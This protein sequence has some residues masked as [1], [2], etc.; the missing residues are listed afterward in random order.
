MSNQVSE[1][2]APTGVGADPAYAVGFLLRQAHVRA[3][4]AFSEALRPLGI[5][6]RHFAVLSSLST[7]TLSQRA[8]VDLIGSDKATMVRIVDDLQAKS[9]VTR[10][11]ALGDR[12]AYAVT[13]TEHGAATL[14]AAQQAARQVATDLLAHMPADDREH[15]IALLTDFTAPRRDDHLR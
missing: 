14:A 11:P 7:Q 12:R 4:R 1:A 10:E 8:L 13:L 2:A 3:A 9:I 15:L 5:E 6:G